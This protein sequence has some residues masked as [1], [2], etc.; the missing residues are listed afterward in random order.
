MNQNVAL[1]VIDRF[2][3][4]TLAFADLH[5]IFFNHGGSFFNTELNE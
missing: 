1:L 2:G 4:D 3:D 5:N